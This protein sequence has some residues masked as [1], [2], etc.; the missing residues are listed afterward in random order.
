[1]SSIHVSQMCLW[2]AG[3]LTGH[4]GIYMG[5]LRAR[6]VI[7]PLSRFL[8][9]MI[10]APDFASELHIPGCDNLPPTVPPPDTQ[11]PRPALSL[12]GTR[13]TVPAC[14]ATRV[15]SLPGVLTSG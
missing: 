13:Q 4:L 8:H 11:H 14:A 7:Y 2:M 15:R 12:L 10:T 1:M 6:D 9:V 5:T 3:L